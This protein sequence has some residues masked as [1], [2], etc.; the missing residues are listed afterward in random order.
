MHIS[1][2]FIYPI[3]SLAGIKL[4]KSKF[5]YLGLEH[6]RRW[7]LI[8]ENNNFIT[9]RELP[10]MANFYPFFEN[11]ILFVRYKKTNEIIEINEE[12]FIVSKKVTIWSAELKA[13]SGTQ[14]Y[15]DWFSERLN[16]KVDLVK[17]DL[18]SKR[19]VDGRYALQKELTAFTDGFPF[20]IIGQESLNDL[21]KRLINPINIERF[22]PNF[23]FEEG[24][25]FVE[26]EFNFFSIGL[27]KFQAVKPCSRCVI[28]TRNT[29]SLISN[30][31]PLKVL[32]KYRMKNNKV[33]FG[34]NLIAGQPKGEIS[35]GDII[36]LN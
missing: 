35:V 17:F 28:I 27:N 6:D 25:A 23:V 30:S 24:D 29:N 16:N 4:E 14:K 18:R 15:R 19:Y 5:D 31:E 12:D 26:D 8:D 36:K 32:A 20:L 3:K 1:Q 10:E 34:Q 13:L 9:Q 7:M 11:N 33:Y 2:I 22:R 21:N